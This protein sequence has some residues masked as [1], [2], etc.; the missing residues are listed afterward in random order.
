MTRAGRMIQVG[1]SPRPWIAVV[2]FS[3]GLLYLMLGITVVGDAAKP[4]I[5]LTG[6]GW[7][8]SSVLWWR[9]RLSFDD[10]GIVTHRSLRPSGRRI[11]WTAIGRFERRGIWHGVGAWLNNGRW[12]TLRSGRLPGTAPRM[13]RWR[14][15]KASA[16]SSHHR[17]VESGVASDRLSRTSRCDTAYMTAA[18]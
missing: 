13:K 15:W 2:Y 16:A 18:R 17:R 5:A 3:L 10:Q 4:W 9:D 11:P 7:M 12:L 1:K 8:L 6:V 14:C